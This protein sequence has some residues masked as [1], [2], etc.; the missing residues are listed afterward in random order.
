MMVKVTGNGTARGRYLMRRPEGTTAADLDDIAATG[1]EGERAW[2]DHLAAPNRYVALLAQVVLAEAFGDTAPLRQTLD[3]GAL[4]D[5]GWLPAAVAPAGGPVAR[6]L[7]PYALSQLANPGPDTPVLAILTAVQAWRTP[8]PGQACVG[9]LDRLR[10]QPDRLDK[11]L[12]SI[13][14]IAPDAPRLAHHLITVLSPRRRLFAR[15]DPVRPGQG[16]L[17]AAAI[18]AAHRPDGETA[19]RLGRLLI[20]SGIDF[21]SRSSSRAGAVVDV[22]SASEWGRGQLRARG[23]TPAAPVD[24]RAEELADGL[25]RQGIVGED[26]LDV[27]RVDG[28]SDI[29]RVLDLLDQTDL[30]VRLDQEGDS[31]PPDYEELIIG[32]ATATHGALIVDDRVAVD[33]APDRGWLV[34]WTAAGRPQ[35][36]R[37]EDLGAGYDLLALTELLE[38]RST[39]DGR[40]LIMIASQ[41]QP[42]F[43]LAR[44]ADW[45]GFVNEVDLLM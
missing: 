33:P 26:V 20:D 13:A 43:V 15:P 21:W 42:T 4:P 36:M 41:E 18:V 22:L 44:P 5:N 32:L 29:A 3:G 45:D 31:S 10:D 1:T 37:V 12:P 9:L 39:S 16:Q 24:P 23:F 7:A 11:A 8:D 17:W 28:T 6:L 35:T 30:V 38:G 34:G 40:A 2:R 19:T 25:V 14:R 27:A